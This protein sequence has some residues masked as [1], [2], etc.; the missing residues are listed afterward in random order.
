[1]VLNSL[2]KIVEYVFRRLSDVVFAKQYK[3]VVHKDFKRIIF[4]D[5][6]DSSDFLRDDDPSKVVNSGMIPV[7]FTLAPPLIIF[8]LSR[9][10]LPCRTAWQR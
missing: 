3:F 9:A 5:A 6:L 4:V 8:V 1:M 7:A 2:D 10:H